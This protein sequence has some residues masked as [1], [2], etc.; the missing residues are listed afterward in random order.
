MIYYDDLILSIGIDSISV[1]LKW[2]KSAIMKFFQAVQQGGANPRLY[3]LCKLFPK[4][5]VR[6]FCNK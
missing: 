4:I 1:Q 3:N 6:D 2:L 5:K